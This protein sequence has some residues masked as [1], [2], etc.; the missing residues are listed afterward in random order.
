MMVTKNLENLHAKSETGDRETLLYDYPHRDREDIQEYLNRITEII[1]LGAFDTAIASAI[2]TLETILPFMAEEE[3]IEYE[4]KNPRELLQVFERKNLI[5]RET[6]NILMQAIALRDAFM[7]KRE[8]E[9]DRNFAEGI[10]AI[11]NNLFR[12]L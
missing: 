1:E 3:N 7:E 2:F 4:T 6:Y 12:S 8:I 9:G 10:F 11:V 5:D